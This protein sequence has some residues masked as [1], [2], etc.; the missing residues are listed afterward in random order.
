MQNEQTNTTDTAGKEPSAAVPTSEK[1]LNIVDEA[2][3]IRDDIK[4]EKESLKEEREKLEKVKSED[5][6]SGESGGNVKVETKEETAKE[7]ADRVMKND[8]G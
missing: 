7:Y 3:A 1:P 6:L 5:I 2:R 4:K 8:R